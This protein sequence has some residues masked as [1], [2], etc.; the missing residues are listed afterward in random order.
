MKRLGLILVGLLAGVGFLRGQVVGTIVAIGPGASL[1]GLTCQAGPCDGT[2]DSTSAM[3]PV[4]KNALALAQIYC[5]SSPC[6]G[7]MSVNM[8]LT[9]PNA[10]CVTPPYQTLITCTNVTSQ[11][12]CVSS[13]NNFTGLMHLS[14]GVQLEFVQSSTSGGGT[15][16]VLVATWVAN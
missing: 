12:L 10:A 14:P 9:C 6:G 16:A 13:P 5:A 4:G 11:G 2:A 1:S 3:I 8:R 15:W 7:N